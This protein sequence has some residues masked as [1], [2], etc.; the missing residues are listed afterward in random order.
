MNG[1]LSTSS[2]LHAQFSE[3]VK[4]L[5]SLHLLLGEGRGEGVSTEEKLAKLGG[6]RY[7]G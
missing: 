7:G 3:S 5:L 2:E 4:P 1:K 6:V